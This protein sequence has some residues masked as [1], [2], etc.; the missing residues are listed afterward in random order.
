MTA[1]RNAMPAEQAADAES[2]ADPT[3]GRWS[4]AEQLQA[5][6]VDVTRQLL[7]AFYLANSSGKGKKPEAP[8]PIARPGVKPARKGPAKPSKAA[9][10]TLFRLI[11]GGAA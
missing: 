10:E 6:Q 8:E 2:G 4:L 3:Q 11:N 1:L 5:A 7:H 9:T